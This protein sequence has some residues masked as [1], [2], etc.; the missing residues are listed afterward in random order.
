MAASSPV[1]RTSLPV[2]GK[3]PQSAVYAVSTVQEE[4]GLRGAQTSAFSIDAQI[5]IAVDVTHATDCPTLDAKQREAVVKLS[6][7]LNSFERKGFLGAP[8]L[9][10]RLCSLRAAALDVKTTR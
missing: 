4:I 1:M 7:S 5:G 2:A 3:K 6:R 10:R 8:R 9:L